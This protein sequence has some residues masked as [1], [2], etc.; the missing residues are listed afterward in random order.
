MRFAFFGFLAC[1]VLPSFSLGQAPVFKVTPEE[2][3][4]DFSVKASVALEGKFEKWTVSTG[5][6]E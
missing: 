6:E 4:I 1:A 3:K 5:S 2:S